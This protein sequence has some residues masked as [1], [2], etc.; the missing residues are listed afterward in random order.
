MP[1]KVSASR[2]RHA[3]AHGYGRVSTAEQNPAHQVEYDPSAEGRAWVE[4]TVASQC[5]AEAASSRRTICRLRRR[6]ARIAFCAPGATWFAGSL[7]GIPLSAAVAAVTAS[8]ALVIFFS[9]GGRALFFS[10]ADRSGEE[11]TPASSRSAAARAASALR[12]RARPAL[13]SRARPALRSR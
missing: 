2:Y 7:A 5:S 11:I 13:L 12:S 10:A 9:A 4:R 1:G 8:L 3:H 6:A